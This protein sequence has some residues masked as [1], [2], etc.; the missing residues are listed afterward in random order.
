[1]KKNKTNFCNPQKKSSKKQNVLQREKKQCRSKFNR[2]KSSSSLFLLH[3]RIGKRRRNKIS[4]SESS[5]K[6]HKSERKRFNFHRKSVRYIP[7]ANFASFCVFVRNLSVLFGILVFTCV[8]AWVCVC[9]R[10]C[11]CVCACVCGAYLRLWLFC[12]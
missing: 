11:G 10:A 12:H 5:L 9:V 6:N 2:F 4:F 1:M 8:L 7:R 3:S